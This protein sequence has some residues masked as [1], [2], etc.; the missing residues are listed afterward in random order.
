MGVEFELE[1]IRTGSWERLPDGSLDAELEQRCGHRRAQ[2]AVDCWVPMRA[3]FPGC[4]RNVL[5]SASESS[6]I[7][8]IWMAPSL[9]YDA[10]VV[11]TPSSA[12]A[13]ATAGYPESRLHVCPLGVNASYQPGVE[14]LELSDGTGRSI[15][16]Y[17]TRF[18][19]VATAL[20]RKNVT[21]LLRTWLRST[22][23]TDDAVLLLKLGELSPNSAGSFLRAMAAVEASVGKRRSEAAP[24]VWHTDVLPDAQMP[25]LF[26]LAT[27]YLTLSHGEGWDL[28]SLQA[29]AMGRRLIVP[30]HSAY[31]DNFDEGS[32]RFVPARAVRALQNIGDAERCILEI[33]PWSLNH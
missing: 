30:R 21:G 7:P 18:L 24:I 27:H 23:R 15:L 29:G 6:S 16:D 28:P 12:R 19:T 8:P 4:R 3:P 33:A 20:P 5:F 1:E 10:V 22:R 13:F 2:L 25:H 32:A 14:P 9:R 31:E 26:A 17:R 11:P